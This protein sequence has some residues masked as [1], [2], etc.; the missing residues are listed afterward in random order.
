[1]GENTAN[2]SAIAHDKRLARWLARPLARTAIS[3]N[4]VTFTG[5][6]VGLCAAWMFARGDTTAAN[7]GGG[8]FIV[9]C[10]LDHLDGELARAAGKTSRFGHYFDNFAMMTTYVATFI[11]IG[12]GLTSMGRDGVFVVLGIAAG[13][14][15]AVIFGMRLWA[16]ER[17]GSDAVAMT[18][19]AGFEIEDAI[20]VVGPVAW[21]GVL[22]YFVIA[23]GIGTPLFLIWLAW[24][25]SRGGRA[26]RSRSATR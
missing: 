17:L 25:M 21:F 12:L 6:V 10:W 4:M 22:D 19:V 15:V 11:G 9:A 8:L 18:P 24:D 20:Y 5:L 26:K 7:W 13:V 14:A 3:P 1:M 23:A 2:T 16:E